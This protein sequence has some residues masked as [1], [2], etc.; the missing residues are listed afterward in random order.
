MTIWNGRAGTQ[1]ITIARSWKTASFGDNERSLARTLIPHLQRAAQVARHK[2]NADLL[3]MAAHSTLDALPHPVFLLTGDGR[4]IYTNRGAEHLLRKADGLLAGREALTAASSSATRALEALIG[5][6]ARSPGK[7]GTLRLSRP[8]G[9]PALALVAIPIRC[10]N[11]FFF[12]A[13]QPAAILCVSDPAERETIDAAVLTALFGLTRAEAEL[14]SALLAGLGTAAQGGEPTFGV[15]RMLAMDRQPLRVQDGQ[16][17]FRCQR[18]RPNILS[19]AQYFACVHNGSRW[20]NF[21]S[22]KGP[23]S[24]PSR[25]FSW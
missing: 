17:R 9:Q 8:S 24:T 5:A 19:Q 13:D 18:T 10:T 22:H 16:S 3:T 20:R 21:S 2:Q 6:A 11:D 4:P 7:G 25:Y 14:A 1:S 23:T 15:V 12:F